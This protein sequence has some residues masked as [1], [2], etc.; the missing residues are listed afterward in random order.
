MDT[1]KKHKDFT[2][3]DFCRVKTKAQIFQTPPERA[4]DSPCS[5]AKGQCSCSCVK[6]PHQGRVVF[7]SCSN[8]WDLGRICTQDSSTCCTFPARR[9]DA[10]SDTLFCILASLQGFIICLSAARGFF[11]SI[12]PLRDQYPLCYWSLEEDEG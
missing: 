7:H 6:Y 10:P 12:T 11:H 1:H 9:V 3:C 4:W 5:T 8:S 2:P